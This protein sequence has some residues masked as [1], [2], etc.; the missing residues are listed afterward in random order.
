MAADG[1][2]NRRDSAKQIRRLRQELGEMTLAERLRI[3]GLDYILKNQARIAKVEKYPDVRRRSVVELAE[4]CN[5]F[6]EHAEQVVRMALALFDQTQTAHGLG[7]R[8]REW[9]EYAALLHDIGVHISYGRH[10]KHSYDLIKNGD[11]RGFEPEEVEV[12]ALVARYHRRGIPKRSHEGYGGLSPALR[13][14]IKTLSAMLRVAEGLDRSHQQSIAAL[15]IIPGGQDYLL[16]IHP[17]GDT[18]LELWAA[19][20]S[21]AP[22]ERVLRRIVR[23]EVAANRVKR[24]S[25]TTRSPQKT[26]KKLGQPT[27]ASDAAPLGRRRATPLTAP[28]A[29]GTTR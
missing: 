10:H 27:K 24:P 22:L 11:L 7:A 14:A 28:A 15:A 17:S 16:Q 5:Y 21:V 9:L 19:Q 25:A 29:G 18:E 4:R 8:E 3:P 26:A 2:R 23:F 12:I 6:A 1:L 13:R 20:R